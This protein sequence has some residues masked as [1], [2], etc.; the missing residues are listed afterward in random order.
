MNYLDLLT[1]IV[2]IIST[3]ASDIASAEPHYLNLG[4]MFRLHMRQLLAPSQVVLHLRTHSLPAST[5]R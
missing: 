4:P 1:T 2:S 5:Q 3:I